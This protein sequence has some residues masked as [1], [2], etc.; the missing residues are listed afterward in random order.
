MLLRYVRRGRAVGLTQEISDAHLSTIY[1][2]RPRPCPTPAIDSNDPIF[3]NASFRFLLSHALGQVVSGTQRV[4][5]PLHAGH[6]WVPTHTRNAGRR[7]SNVTAV[8]LGSAS[9]SFGSEVFWFGSCETRRMSSRATV[10]HAGCCDLTASCTPERRTSDLIHRCLS[11]PL[12][13]QALHI[14]Q[15]LGGVLPL[16]RISAMIAFRL[17]DEE[18]DG[19]HILPVA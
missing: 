8:A 18:I 2:P 10:R 1:L 5:L 17:T 11:L 16:R 4:Q 3:I 9:I 6:G 12:T 13:E 19:C 15:A 7:S 14:P